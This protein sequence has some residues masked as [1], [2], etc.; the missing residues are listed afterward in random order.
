MGWI[1]LILLPPFSTH[2]GW[3]LSSYFYEFFAPLCHQSPERCFHLL[4]EP[5]AVCTRCLGLY[6][7]VLIGLMVCPLLPGLTEMLL[8]RP[9]MMLLFTIPMGLD[10]LVENTHAS[11][12]FSGLI[13]SFPIALFIWIAAEQFG[14]SF[15]G[16]VRSYTWSRKEP[17]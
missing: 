17:T 2:L 10:L 16:F 11:R 14:T 4:A 9:R 13:A 5:V 6:T 7:G 8:E 12:Y 1:A 3:P 15:Y